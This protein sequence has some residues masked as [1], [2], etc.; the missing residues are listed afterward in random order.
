MYPYLLHTWP[1][2]LQSVFLMSHPYWSTWAIG[3]YGHGGWSFWVLM[4]AAALCFTYVST[5]PLVRLI[6]A[7]LIEP[8]WLLKGQSALT[9]IS[10]TGSKKMGAPLTHYAE[11]KHSDQCEKPLS[12]P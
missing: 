3:S 12:S 9:E 4:G 5:L 8:D 1:L 7:P 11:L 2:T 10:L 6:F